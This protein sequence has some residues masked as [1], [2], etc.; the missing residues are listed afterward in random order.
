MDLTSNR[1]ITW[2]LAV[3]LSHACNMFKGNALTVYIQLSLLYLQK[4]ANVLWKCLC[5]RTV[6]IILAAVRW[7]HLTVHMQTRVMIPITTDGNCWDNN[8]WGCSGRDPTL[9]RK[10]KAT[11]L[12]EC[13]MN[14]QGRTMSNASECNIHTRCA[15]HLQGCFSVTEFW[16]TNLLKAAHQSACLLLRQCYLRCEVHQPLNLDEHLTHSHTPY[17][18]A[19]CT[20]SGACS[21]GSASVRT[22]I[23]NLRTAAVGRPTPVTGWGHT[24]HWPIA[25]VMHVRTYI[26]ACIPVPDIYTDVSTTAHDPCSDG[27]TPQANSCAHTQR[28]NV[29][30]TH[31][32]VC[33]QQNTQPHAPHCMYPTKH[34][35]GTVSKLACIQ[36]SM[37]M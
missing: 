9:D 3:L 26:G 35:Q 25:A 15:S 37:Y 2:V 21:R 4:F 19:Q 30:C 13:K 29:N 24:L 11:E 17:K 36:C 31:H 8:S 32:T 28:P 14:G 23:Q 33:T 7:L 5:I 22:V 34:R 6:V 1:P 10:V 18:K 16:E 12:V 27:H 20:W